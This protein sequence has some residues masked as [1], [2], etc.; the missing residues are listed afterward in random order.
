LA[1]RLT[2]P[3]SSYHYRHARIGGDK[4][5]ALRA[6]IISLFGASSSR[7][8]YRR[9]HHCLGLRISEKVVRRI[10]RREALVAHIP[11]RR[12]H[13]SYQGETTPAP[14]NLIDR[15]F[16]AARPNMKW[17]TDITEIKAGDGK[18]YCSPMI[19]CYDGRTVT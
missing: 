10:M 8:G 13:G 5:A 6:R 3:L 16:T 4:Y 17:L 14:D 19:D 1:R 7:Y 15:D 11:R 9:I 2:I 12:H 18:V